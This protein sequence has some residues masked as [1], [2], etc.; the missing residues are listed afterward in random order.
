MQSSSCRR[1]LSNLNLATLIGVGI[2]RSGLWNV[3]VSILVLLWVPFAEFLLGGSNAGLGSKDVLINT[4]AWHLIVSWE[5]LWLELSL[6][7]VIQL[8]LGFGQALLCVFNVVINSEVWYLV[9]DFPV[10]LVPGRFRGSLVPWGLLSSWSIGGLLRDF[11]G[12]GGS[13][14]DD[15]FVHF[16]FIII[17]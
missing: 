17:I 2:T 11:H 9:V 7:L 12:A 15:Q 5:W 6:Q 1:S 4:E 10:W 14:Q 13:G 8:L 16:V 3:P